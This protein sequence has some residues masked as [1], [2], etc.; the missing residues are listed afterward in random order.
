MCRSEGGGL[1]ELEMI[2][3]EPGSELVALPL[4]DND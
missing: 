1:V 3:L 2:A 4:I